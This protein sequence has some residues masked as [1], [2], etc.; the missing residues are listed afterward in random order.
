[1]FLREDHD[2]ESE[3]ARNLI[4]RTEREIF[5][6]VMG[7]REEDLPGSIDGDEDD[8]E[9]EQVTGWD[10]EPLSEEEIAY[11]ALYGDDENNFDR[12]LAA[13]HE[14]DVFS[15]NEELRREL[16]ALKETNVAIMGTDYVRAQQEQERQRL[17]N[18]LI[19]AALDNA[20]GGRAD[21]LLGTLRG[22]QQQIYNIG[23]NRVEQSMQAAHEAYGADFEDAMTRLST[24]NPNDPLARQIV[25]SITNSDDP[26]EALMQHWSDSP[27]L[28]ALHDRNRPPPFMPGRR[29]ASI[30]SRG[31]PRT[32]SRGNR[33]GGRLTSQ[34][35]EDMDGGGG[36][37]R[38][39][40]EDIFNF[41]TGE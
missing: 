39:E 26:G 29:S 6:D 20:P 28:D 34:E 36:Y 24:M 22:Q 21:Q 9:L 1:M 2:P 40:E 5:A 25:Q 38:G 4:G 31:S 27:I 41:A 13:Q 10:G 15:E 33:G 3:T 16:A 8:S 37:G 30:P 23:A 17:H 12:P 19:E 7:Q 11:R 14:R 32:I 35:L 18:D